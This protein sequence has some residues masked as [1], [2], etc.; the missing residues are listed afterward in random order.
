MPVFTNDECDMI[1]KHS[2]NFFEGLKK[3]IVVKLQAQIGYKL[4]S[5]LDSVLARLSSLIALLKKRNSAGSGRGETIKEE[6]LI[7]EEFTPLIKRVILQQRRLVASKLEEPMSKTFHPELIGNLEQELEP[8][9]K[10]MDAPWFQEAQALRVPH[11]TEFLA[12]KFVEEMDKSPVVLEK[13]EYDEKFHILQTPSLFPK[14]LRYF[15]EKCE[16]RSNGLMVAYLDV[17]D[18]KSFNTRYTETRVDRDIL[19]RFMELMETHL[20]THGFGYR[21][22]GDEYIMLLPNMSLNMGVGFIKEFQ[23]K[24]RMI[25]YRGIAEKTTVSIGALFVSADCFLTEKEIEDRANRAKNFAKKNG[26][27]CIATYKGAFYAESDLVI[28]K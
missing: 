26:K 27:N 19:P 13:R 2:E 6:H 28:V 8:I 16:L 24:L 11:L 10:L 14:D 21:Y 17:D 4:P 7:P 18:F 22:G 1:E 25:S 15:R 20:Y 23:Q 5:E 9:K 12:I 3:N